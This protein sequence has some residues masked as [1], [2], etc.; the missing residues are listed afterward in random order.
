MCGSNWPELPRLRRLTLERRVN[1][2]HLTSRKRPV[3]VERVATPRLVYPRVPDRCLHRF[4][5]RRLGDVVALLPPGA[6]VERAF[7]GG[8]DVL[9]RPLPGGVRVFP[10]KRVRQ[11]SLAEAV[12]QVL[13]MQQ[14]H[15]FELAA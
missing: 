3:V 5:Q 9:P 1:T 12:T 13:L 6:W 7:R 11:L 14:P 4:L 8:E 10:L 15:P 2:D